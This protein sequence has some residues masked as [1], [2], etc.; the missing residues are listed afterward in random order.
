MSWLGG[1]GAGEVENILSM[2]EERASK[3]GSSGAEQRKK[4]IMFLDV[5]LS[6]YR[7]LLMIAAGS[8]RV[9][10]EDYAQELKRAAGGLSVLQAQKALNVILLSQRWIESNANPRLVLEVLFLEIRKLMADS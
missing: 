9:L 6:W 7:D 5:V 3:S 4:L 1:N 8:S 10:N 2:A